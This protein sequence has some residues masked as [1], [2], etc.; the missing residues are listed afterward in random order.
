MAT[1]NLSL[2]VIPKVEDERTYEVVD[3][4][5]KVI[6]ESGVKYLVGPMETTMEGEL[7]TLWEVVKKAQ[8]ACIRAGA[9]RVMSVIKIDYKPEG[10]TMEEKIHKYRS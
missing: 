5:I 1:V 6:R 2:Q 7:D 3:E 8:D 9:S 4:A 10:V